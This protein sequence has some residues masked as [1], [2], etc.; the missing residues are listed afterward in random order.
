MKILF[1][2]RWYPDPPDNGSKIRI[3]NLLRSLC[4]K[5]SISLISFKIPGE[6]IS[7]KSFP[8]PCPVEIQV[9]PY[10]EFN[11]HNRRALL[12][13]FSMEPRSLVDTYSKEMELL[14]REAVNKKKFDLI[15]AS[16]ISMAAY[17]K[18]FGGTPAIFEELELGNYYP[19]ESQY[20][21]T[22]QWI[23]EKLR[24]AKYRNFVSSLLPNFKLCTVASE[25]E[26]KLAAGIAPRYESFHLIPNSIDM[27]LYEIPETAKKKNSLI[28]TGSL[29]YIANYEAVNWFLTDIYP[30]IISEIQDVNLT[31]TGDPG[32][33]F[34]PPSSNVTMTGRVQNVHKLIA[35]SRISIVPIRTG[36]GTRLKILEAFA[37]GTLVVATS[38]AAEGLSAESNI[39]YLCADTPKEF[40][41]CVQDVL[42]QPE[43]AR[44][45]TA[46]AFNFVKSRY[47]WRTLSR[48]FMDL[49]DQ[50]TPKS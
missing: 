30:I 5:H 36:G 7:I 38:K 48:N 46:R 43:E 2:S 1:L 29:R 47:D 45:M 50:A 11:P 8:N 3:L 37:L 16:Q 17:Y 19:N 49:V 34:L 14:I 10:S 6:K 32:D 23:R 41:Q 21:Y 18:C 31:I 15:I 13:Y 27:S 26:R 44:R 24:W 20:R 12:G 35:E 33:K 22:F 40:A 4:E 28:F 39:H 9:C 25:A 42:R